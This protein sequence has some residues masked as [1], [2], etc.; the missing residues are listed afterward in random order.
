LLDCHL[1]RA[2]DLLGRR[3]QLVIRLCQPTKA[4]HRSENVRLLRCERIT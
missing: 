2:H 3:L 1:L 4:L